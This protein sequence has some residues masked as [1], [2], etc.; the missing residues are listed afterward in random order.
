MPMSIIYE[1]RVWDLGFAFQFHPN[2]S[3]KSEPYFDKYAEKS[4]RLNPN[5][6]YLRLYLLSIES[7]TLKDWFNRSRSIDCRI[8]EIYISQGNWKRKFYV[9]LAFYPYNGL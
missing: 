7:V 9:L 6:C 1:I 3:W 8:I 5:W 2:E 4:V